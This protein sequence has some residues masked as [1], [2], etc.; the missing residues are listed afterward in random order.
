MTERHFSEKDLWGF[1]VKLKQRGQEWDGPPG[2][3][4]LLIALNAK[5]VPLI[6]RA[7]RAEAALREIA[8]IGSSR[9]MEMGPEDDGDGWWKRIG[10]R[11]I[12]TAARALHDQSKP[13]NSE[14]S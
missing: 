1:S 4:E 8:F 12:S 9:P 6:E 2:G 10:A 13:E 3:D 14:E 7:E 11:C 5:V